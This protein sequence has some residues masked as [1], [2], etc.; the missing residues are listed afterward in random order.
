MTTT[1]INYKQ[2]A[3]Q[4][5]Q[6]LDARDNHKNAIDKSIWDTFINATGVKANTIQSYIEK[7]NAIKSFV[8]YLKNASDDILK[9]IY[10]YCGINTAVEENNKEEETGTVNKKSNVESLK[11]ILADANLEVTDEEEFVDI[12]AKYE[13][14]LALRDTFQFTDKSIAYDIVNYVNAK[15]KYNPVE[16]Q[17][18]RDFTQCFNSE[19]PGEETRKI[20]TTYEIE[21][22]KDA[23]ALANTNI[24]EA[25]KKQSEAYQRFGN[26]QVQLY[27]KNGDNKISKDEFVA[28]EEERCGSQLTD[29]EQSTAEK[30]FDYLKNSVT[31][32]EFIDVQEM[33]LHGYAQA[34]LFDNN[35]VRSGESISYQE[36]AKNT[37]DIEAH[38]NG[39][40]STDTS[41]GIKAYE[42][43][44]E[45]GKNVIYDYAKYLKQQHK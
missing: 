42:M 27:D 29:Y 9:K 3:E 16:D 44:R 11:A 7:P 37:Q 17:F 25:Y 36:W 19:N 40:N 33:T 35:K 10:S 39:N 4:M 8:Y 41:D 22:I 24:N 26:S 15:Q 23:L 30:I 38:V 5:W 12:L 21:G 2:I 20:R 13:N 6:H 1:S 31:D 43:W 18:K 28:Y 45:M 14:K 32:D 34:H